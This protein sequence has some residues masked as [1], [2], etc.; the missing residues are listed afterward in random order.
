M[1]TAAVLFI[2]KMWTARFQS[3]SPVSTHKQQ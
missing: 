2:V 1:L 3:E